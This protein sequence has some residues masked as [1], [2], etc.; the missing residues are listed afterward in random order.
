MQVQT[1]SGTAQKFNGTT[2][3]LCGNYYQRKGKRLHREVWE[4]H[5]GEI[6]EG[7][8]VH[9]ID[10]DRND[11]NIDNLQLM[12]RSEHHSLHMSEP[13]RKE[14]SRE[15]IKKAAEAAKPWHKTERGQQFHSEHAKEYWASAKMNTYTCVY[16]GKE[17]QT[18]HIYGQYDNTFCCAKHKAY[19]RKEQGIDNETKTCPVCGKEFE[20][21][22]YAK[23]VC[24]S[25][26]CAT[27][28]RWG[29]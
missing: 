27:K 24:C 21:N 29:K 23:K 16:C 13:E 4:Y 6:P 20:A 2:Y 9:H 5:N 10:G 19:W 28:K 25:K 17:F 1:I 14:Q 7:Y 11:N 8:D 26:S 12:L 22:R 3:Y 15:N 18:K